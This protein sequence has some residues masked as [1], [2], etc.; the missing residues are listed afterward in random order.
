V[1]EV[2][3][4]CSD[5]DAD[6]LSYAVVDEPAHGAVSVVAG[7]LRYVPA[8]DYDGRDSFSYRADDGGAAS[9]VATA[10]IT[11]AAVNDA[12]VCR[13][14]S[15][16]TQ[17]DTPVELSPAC[18][19][20]DSGSLSYAIVGEPAHGAVSVVAG[21]LRYAPAGGYGGADSFTYKA[22]DGSRDSVAAPAA[23][24]VTAAVAAPAVMR[25]QAPRLSVFGPAG[26]PV[27]CRMASGVIGACSVRLLGGRRV[28]ARGR[29]VASGSGAGALTV[30]LRLTR[31][32]R[33]RLARHL[34]GVR[35]R[36]AATGATSGGTRTAHA[37]TRA[38]Q[39]VE[40]FITPPGAW[41]P[42][43]AALSPRGR[44]FLHSRRARLI[45]VAAV[46]CDGYSAKVRAHAPNAT[47]ISLARAAAVCA[48]LHPR[49]ANPTPTVIGHG[50][51]RPIASN[52][53]A[54]G[55]ARN[56]RVEVTITHR[57]TRL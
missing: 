34:G 11:V 37:R 49:G 50:D 42:D 30:R 38:I 47:R 2:A 12:P 9:N 27:R 25:V 26:S 53:T 48:A 54:A 20:V 40:R 46:R 35:G 44:R 21:R 17:V 32:G 1:L 39:A 10:S 41:L 22:G 36:V 23:I 33:A 6:A 28:L 3:P 24:T 5:V 15:A 29:A 18:A 14:V 57:H 51:S 4:S 19:D 55:R 8:A 56:R 52:T 13:A 43:Q 16:R 7:R 45:A 31:R